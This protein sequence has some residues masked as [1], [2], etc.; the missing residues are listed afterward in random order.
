MRISVY[1]ASWRASS[2][3]CIASS[4]VGA[5][6][7]MRAFLPRTP[8]PRR[9][10]EGRTKAAVLPVPVRARPITSWPSSAGGMACAWIGVGASKPSCLT[11]R[12]RGASKLN[13]S[14]LILPFTSILFGLDLRQEN[15]APDPGAV[16]R[17][18]PVS[19]RRKYTTLRSGES[20]PLFAPFPF[21]PPLVPPLGGTPGGMSCPP[22]PLQWPELD[23][24]E[25]AYIALEVA[26]DSTSM[27]RGCRLLER[28][29]H[30]SQMSRVNLRI[31][32]SAHPPGLRN[33]A[34]AGGCGGESHSPP[35]PPS[36]KRPGAKRTGEG[37]Q[38]A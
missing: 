17:A 19:L 1:C 35:L 32:Q 21:H 16:C 6:T 26:S 33:P 9:W 10:S 29:L 11:A 8:A 25:G 4:R 30:P 5:S 37:G 27:S 18:D 15:T 36:A 20:L 2:V 31:A 3:I 38:T 13:F 14:K 12:S 24:E 28:V 22:D 7:T 34:I 23:G